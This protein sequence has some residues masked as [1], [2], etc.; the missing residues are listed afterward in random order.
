MNTLLQV[1][2][3]IINDHDQRGVTENYSYVL[4]MAMECVSIPQAV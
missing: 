4:V 2:D 1:P 3:L